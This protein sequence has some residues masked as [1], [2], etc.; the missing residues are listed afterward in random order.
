M[1]PRRQTN[2]YWEG[3]TI[4]YYFCKSLIQS[5]IEYIGMVFII[6][7]NIEINPH[8]KLRS[9]RTVCSAG[10]VSTSPH[11]NNLRKRDGSIIRKEQSL[12]L[13]R[14]KRKVIIFFIG[15][16][17][18]PHHQEGYFYFIWKVYFSFVLTSIVSI[19]GA[20]VVRQHA[21]TQWLTN[22]YAVITF[23]I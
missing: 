17:R 3:L 20:K 22:A 10:S 8:E 13:R 12:P 1:L 9:N 21:R 2:Y 4:I 18:H 6:S 16:G 15:E 11:Y 7:F 19:W 23:Y 5:S 14:I